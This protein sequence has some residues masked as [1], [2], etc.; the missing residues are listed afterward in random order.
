MRSTLRLQLRSLLNLSVGPSRTY[1]NEI[2][3]GN[4]KG[5]LLRRGLIP[6]YEVHA[7]NTRM[8]G[9]KSALLNL[10]FLGLQGSPSSGDVLSNQWFRTPE[11]NHAEG[12]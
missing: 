2:Y 4:V 9:V 5:I 6:G 1:T 12:A 8:I 3:L 7:T 11:F 10:P